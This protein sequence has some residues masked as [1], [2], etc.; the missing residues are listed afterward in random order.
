ARL[1]AMLG[2][3]ASCPDTAEAGTSLALLKRHLF[4]DSGPEPRDMDGTVSVA[5]WPGEAR[6]CVEIARRIQEEA[7]A[8]VPFDR[9]AIFLRSPNSYRSH[10]EEALRRAAIPTHFARGAL[11]PDPAG[12]ALLALLAC[13]AEGLSARR[14]AEYL[15]LGQVPDPD[16]VPDETWAPPE[17]DLAPAVAVAPAPGT[18]GAPSGAGEGRAPDPDAGVSEG[19]LRAPWRWERLLVDAAVIGGRDRWVRRLDGLMEEIALR[20]KDLDGDDA[21]AGGLERIAADL[22]HLRAFALPLITR[23]SELPASATWAVWLEQLQSLTAAALRRPHG[24]LGVLAELAPL[25]PVGPVD[26]VVVQ[27]VLAPRLRELAAP[28]ASRPEGAVFVAP[29]EMAR[30]LMFDV[31]FVPGMAEKLFPPRILEDPLLPDEARRALG[32]DLLATQDSRVQEHRLALRLAV[33]AA[34]RHA[35]LS[36]PRV[37]VEMARARVPSF[38]GLEAIRAMEGRLPGFDELRGRGETGGSSKLGWPAPQNPARAIDDTEYDLAI[39]GRLKDAADGA[40]AGAANYLLAANPHL[41]RALRSRGRRWLKKWSFADGLVDPD[42]EALA[43]LERHRMG[44]RSFSPTALERFASCP[45]QFFLQAVQRIQPREEAEALETIDP[46]TRGALFHEIQFEL[47]TALRDRGKLPLDPEHLEEAYRI[48]E[49]AASRVA[50]QWKEKVAPAIPRVWSDGIGAIR[51]DL[52]EWLR[53]S[54][55]SAHGWVPHRFELSFGLADRDRPTADRSSVPDPVTILDGVRL[56][57]SV[58]L[59]ERRADGALRV[60]D[61]K[62]GK[63]RVDAGAVVW[64]GRT[65]QPLLYALAVEELL[66]GRVLSGRLYYCT[67]DGGFEERDIR[68]D[69]DNRAAARAAIGVI[70]RALEQGFL[71]AAPRPDACRWCDYRPVCGPNEEVRTARKTRERLEDLDYLREMQ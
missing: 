61:H 13:A 20:R 58:D 66:Q 4:E 27:H 47:L 41:A 70:G 18:P 34:G 14:F 43:A 2:V 56:R 24:V 39:L 30:G 17:H 5:S 22:D 50:D 9:M 40:H 52:R 26:L 62:T 25:G 63:A 53:R 49:E 69:E 23:L 68:L 35:A 57:G 48:L 60:T 51:A 36:W 38:Y 55:E 7:S 8:G 21:R 3:P 28:P 15:S 12:R 16:G 19:T 33:G 10:L 29:I 44:A 64:G 1:E 54:T 67:S 32:A 59:V 45:Y 11:R 31:V 42:A 65:L 46:L 71:P 37:D 6:E